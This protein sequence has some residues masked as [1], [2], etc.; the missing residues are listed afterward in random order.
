MPRFVKRPIEID[1]IQW[2]GQNWN[3]VILF[4]TE[5]DRVG[6]VP[7]IYVRGDEDNLNNGWEG[8]MPI[9]IQTLE[10]EMRAE[11]GDW[12]IKGIADE[13]YPCKKEI[14]EAT[15]DPVTESVDGL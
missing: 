13:V 12:I 2:T 10:G 5:D 6:G 14:F 8:R 7:A 9:L 3:D 4:C 11:I 1:A 15:Y